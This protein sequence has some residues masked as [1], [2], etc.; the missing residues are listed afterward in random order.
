MSKVKNEKL[1]QLLEHL[2]NEIYLLWAQINTYQQLYI[3]ESEKRHKL[4]QDTAPGFFLIVQ[5][6]LLESILMRISRLIDPA[7]SCRDENS[8]FKNLSDCLDQGGSV[9]KELQNIFDDWKD[10]GRFSSL[11]DLRNKVLSH[12]DF[13]LNRLLIF[14]KNDFLNTTYSVPLFF[15]HYIS[16]SLNDKNQFFNSLLSLINWMVRCGMKLHLSILI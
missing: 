6:S 9:K 12:N 1:A 16:W 8:S 10:G 4:L 15:P 14:R 3:V 5:M 7:K 2:G 11:R 13:Q